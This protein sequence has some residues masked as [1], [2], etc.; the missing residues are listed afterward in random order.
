MLTLFLYISLARVF[1]VVCLL[2]TPPLKSST[3]TI[4]TH[5]TNE[6]R[7]PLTACFQEYERLNP[8]TTILHRQLSYRD[9]LQTLFMARIGGTA[10]DIYNLSTIWT[11]QLVQSDSLAVP[12]QEVSDFVKREYLEETRE[13]MTTGGHVWGIPSEVN[14]YMLVYNKLLF[15]RAGLNRPPATWDELVA[16]AVKI[17]KTNR[18]GQ[19]T[20]AGFGFGPSPTQAV[21]PFLALLY[22]SGEPLFAADQRSTNLTTGAARSILEGQVRL[23]RA[24]GTNIGVTPTQ[25]PS[26]SLGMMIVPNWWKQEL[27]QGLRQRFAETVGVAPIPGGVNWRT[28]Q[29]GFYWAVDAK[30]RHAGEAW[31]LLEWLNTARAGHRSCV[32]EMLLGLGS[33]TGNKADLA[34]SE[35]EIGDPFMKPFADALADGRALPEGTI[36]HANEIEV[37]MRSYIEEAWLGL[38]PP[39]KA[40]DEAD[41]IIRMILQESE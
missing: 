30:S 41:A 35:K 28:V 32:G 27:L 23:F 13:A 24:K 20:T 34:A 39:G 6:Q 10:P 38:L 22:S 3:L 1:T 40:L 11:A 29:Y 16:D 19:L 14:V 4:A 26:G 25:F 36:P 12:P 2:L 9:F 17:S 15:A 37:L 31:K 18:Q 8:G 21:S 7:A 5:Y 33:L